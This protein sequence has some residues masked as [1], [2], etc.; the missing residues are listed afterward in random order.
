MS[1]NEIKSIGEASKFLKVSV[2]TLRRWS[3]LGK[4]KFITTSGGH[5]RYLKKDLVDFLD[6][7]YSLI[8][9]S[10]K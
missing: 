2:K 4:I 3:N 8:I 1:N 10:E 9:K 5:R 6:S 7:K